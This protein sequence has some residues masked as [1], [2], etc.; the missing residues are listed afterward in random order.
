MKRL[1]VMFFTAALCLPIQN[2]LVSIAAAADTSSTQMEDMVVTATRTEEPAKEFPGRVDVITREQLKEM[3]VQT[4]DEALSYIAGV[5]QERTSGTN[6][7]QSTVSL[8]GFGN[9]QGRTLVLLDGVPL[10]S[11]DGGSVNWNRINM[12]DIAR[13]EILKGPASAIYGSYAM[14]GVINIITVKPTK[15]FEGSSSASFGTN[16]D[17][18]LRGVAAGRSSDDPSAVYARVSG[19]YHT[20]QGYKLQP[21]NEWNSATRKTFM[22]EET[23]ATK[24]GWDLSANAN[25]E[26]QY[27]KD[28]QTE[29]EGT[30]YLYNL[31]NTRGF[32]TDSWQVKFTGD[33]EG[34]KSMINAYYVNVNYY[35]T[36][37]TATLLSN[38]NVKPGTYSLY[39]TNVDRKN[40]GIMTNLSH[41]F[42]PHTVT[43]GV[44]LTAGEMDGT[45]Y[46]H[47]QV[48]FDTDAG[49][50]W[51]IGPFIQDQMR[52]F[53]DKLIIVG[54]LRYDNATTYQ[55]FTNSNLTP[56]M[57]AASRHL[58]S[59]TWDAWSPRAS[60]KYFF[61]DNLDAYFSYGHAFR[62]P[63]LDAMYRTGVRKNNTLQYANPNLGP[64]NSDTLEVGADYQPMPNLRFS[65]SGYHSVANDYISSVNVGNT[66]NVQNQNISQ[67]EIWGAEFTA[68][69]DPF[70]NMGTELWKKFTL[71]GNYTCNESRILSF[72]GSPQYEGKILTNTPFNTVNLGYSWLNKYLNNRVSVQYVGVMFSDSA[73]TASQTIN[74][75]TMV[76]AKVWRNFD[77]LGD[78]GKNFNVAFSV[79]NIFDVRYINSFGNGSNTLNEGRTMYLELS[80]KF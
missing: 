13:I 71:F 75:H 25:L 42:G 66:K 45:D 21:T 2:R 68:E 27:I 52:F 38:G 76:N 53:D 28:W 80:C 26:M 60:I 44:D 72:S 22:D 62:A 10:N 69:Y 30:K 31:G 41:T 16:E 48:G 70:V 55:G 51:T 3:P 47:T 73:N 74:P 15:R 14:G 7:F 29:G 43:A 19:L 54:G 40:Y 65:T 12:E 32:Q 67:V 35:R 57:I 11:A 36:Y 17:W 56:A 46:Y 78:Y 58:P 6:S 1:F 4:V 9:D 34:W 37:E 49:K 5:H 24:L 77:F 61:L 8:R 23:I 79:E 63:G 20:N 59:K 33:W 64:E 39:D 50:I 18:K